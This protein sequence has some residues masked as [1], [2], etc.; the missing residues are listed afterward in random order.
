M[1]YLKMQEHAGIQKRKLEKRFTDE[2]AKGTTLLPESTWNNR[3]LE[4][5]WKDQVRQVAANTIC[6]FKSP[7]IFSL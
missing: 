3:L 2:S 7:G 6:F 5:T 4:S 1:R